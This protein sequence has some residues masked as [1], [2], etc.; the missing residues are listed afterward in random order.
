MSSGARQ[1]DC[2][3]LDGTPAV[4]CHLPELPDLDVATVSATINVVRA[5]T[6]LQSGLIPAAV[7]LTAAWRPNHPPADRQRA[8]S[9]RQS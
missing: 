7:S 3:E 6:S 9:R 1:N 2:I 5:A 4:H 8:T